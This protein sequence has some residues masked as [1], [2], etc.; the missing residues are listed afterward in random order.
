M[1]RCRADIM[2]MVYTPIGDLL[3]KEAARLGRAIPIH[4]CVDTGLG[5]VGVPY[6][7][8]TAL[9]R[10]LGSRKGITIAAR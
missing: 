5:R 7:E 9:I 2:P 8:A 4:V 1:T 10:G 3:E 6:R